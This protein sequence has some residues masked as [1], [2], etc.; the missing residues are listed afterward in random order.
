MRDVGHAVNKI[1]KLRED[2]ASGQFEKQKKREE[3]MADRHNKIKQGRETPEESRFLETRRDERVVVD[4]IRGKSPYER[5][6]EEKTKNFRNTTPP[7][8]QHY[9]KS[10]HSKPKEGRYKEGTPQ[11]RRSYGDSPYRR[12]SPESEKSKKV[13]PK[14]KFEDSPIDRRPFKEEKKATR[15]G[16]RWS[17]GYDE[18]DHR[19]SSSYKSSSRTG[20]RFSSNGSGKPQGLGFAKFTWKR[21]DKKES[22]QNDPDPPNIS[23][24]DKPSTPKTPEESED[25]AKVNIKPGNKPPFTPKGKLG[26][27]GK[28]GNLAPSTQVRTT[29]APPTKVVKAPSKVTPPMN[30]VLAASTRS[31]PTTKPSRPLGIAK[32]GSDTKKPEVV[33]VPVA[34]VKSQPTTELKQE[35]PPPGTE[36]IFVAPGKFF[37]P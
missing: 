33:N 36:D 25:K 3:S 23:S 29:K 27:G 7:S 13:A 24:K 11:S 35:P 5:T 22:S 34:E 2:V 20:N 21:S 8:R 6:K 17:P 31:I 14:R 37:H 26:L 10:P 12:Q 18:Y 16:G 30:A 9:E 19:N 15:H 32:P 1:K 4:R 28:V